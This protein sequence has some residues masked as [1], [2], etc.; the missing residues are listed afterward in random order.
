MCLQDLL[1]FQ[2][3]LRDYFSR[4]GTSS[5]IPA[6]RQGIPICERFLQLASLRSSGAP[7]AAAPA[8]TAAVP[9]AVGAPVVCIC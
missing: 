4:L 1:I 3:R 6:V 2:R 5:E 7:V 8:A 9:P